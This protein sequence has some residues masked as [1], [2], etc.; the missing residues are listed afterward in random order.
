[1]QDPVPA[2]GWRGLAVRVCL[3]SRPSIVAADSSTSTYLDLDQARPRLR[4]RLRPRPNLDRTACQ[5]LRVPGQVRSH[6]IDG[7]TSPRAPRAHVTSARMSASARSARARSTRRFGRRQRL[8]HLRRASAARHW[9]RS[10]P[11]ATRAVRFPPTAA[12]HRHHRSHTTRRQRPPLRT[13]ASRWR[14]DR[15]M[16]SRRLRRTVRRRRCARFPRAPSLA[17]RALGSDCPPLRPLA[18]ALPHARPVP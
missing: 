7:C 15:C 5:Q 11:P 1:M 17:S 9:S 4:P 10:R 12:R 2:K 8:D 14:R 13:P 6:T 18:L 16:R 3:V